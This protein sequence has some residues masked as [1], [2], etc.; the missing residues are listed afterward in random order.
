MV[1]SILHFHHPK[2]ARGQAAHLVSAFARVVMDA[3]DLGHVVPQENLVTIL[4]RQG[5]LAHPRQKDPSA[6]TRTIVN[7]VLLRPRPP[8]PR[9][10]YLRAFR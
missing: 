10:S 2:C 1:R 5:Y 6:A 7:E 8:Y 9:V 4:S 3:F